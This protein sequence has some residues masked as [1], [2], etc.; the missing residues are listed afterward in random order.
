MKSLQGKWGLPVGSM[1]VLLAVGPLLFLISGC[2]KTSAQSNS[3][4]GVSS[5]QT[6]EA[7]PRVETVRVAR[8]DLTKTVEMPGTV[9]GFESAELYAKVG[10]YLKTIQVD[11]G[12]RIKKGQE[13]ARLD[14]PEMDKQLAQK[15]ASVNQAEAEL[16]QA[17]AIID[18]AEAD[19]GSAQAALDEATTERAE[20]Q[21]QLDY[22]QTD[23]NRIRELVAR[24]ALQ[25][26]LLDQ[27]KFQFD[28]A[29]AALATTAARIRTAEAK[30]K[31]AEANL[32]KVQADYEAA[33]A[34]LDVAKADEDYVRSLMQYAVIKAPFD[35]VVTNRYVHP[36]AFIQPAEG[37]SAARPL[38]SVSCTDLVRVFLDIPMNDVRLLDRG[39]RAVL[40]RINVLPSEEFEGK[41]TRSSAALNVG[42]RMMRVEIDLPNPDGKLLPGLYGYMTVYL[43]ELPD[44]PVVPSSALLTQGEDRYV[45]VCEDGR[46]QKRV[47]HTNYQ[48][49]TW[50]G[51]ADGLEGG[52]QVV[53]AGG[54]QIADNQPVTAVLAEAVNTAVN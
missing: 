25:Q 20:K 52:E 4:T 7:G 48:D 33:Q 32:A 31:G 40:S 45:F 27:A 53:R 46:A 5:K 35:G 49:G 37:N 18:Q 22:R 26:E 28:A 30:L 15:V 39:D 41:V 16:K 36:G 3:S 11:I 1:A 43:E 29:G 38:L 13:L 21:A 34:R 42:S 2:G 12:D 6:N 8:R 44:V 17:K 50:V 24:K 54:G 19:L 9:E 10:G 23:F 51:I 47:V 14:I